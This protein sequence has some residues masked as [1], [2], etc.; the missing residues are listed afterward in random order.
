MPKTET[1]SIIVLALVLIA[2]GT[3]GFLEIKQLQEEQKA[4]QKSLSE[5]NQ[6]FLQFAQST[7]DSLTQ[8]VSDLHL[9]RTAFNQTVENVRDSL[10]EIE[11][12]SEQLKN[13]S[14]ERFSEL[15]QSI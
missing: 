7:S 10:F 1:I 4:L 5:S 15:E 3:F 11:Q 6:Q 8:L 9:T 12:Q 2:V 14:E 13:Q